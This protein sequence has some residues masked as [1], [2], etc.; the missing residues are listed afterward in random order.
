MRRVVAHAKLLSDDR[1]NAACG[2]D[3]TAEAERFG[4]AG[5]QRRNLGSLLVGQLGLRAG[6]RLT[7]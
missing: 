4:T 5:Q 1:R 2:P 3:G 6:R 7:A